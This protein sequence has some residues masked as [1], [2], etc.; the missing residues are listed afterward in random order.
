MEGARFYF[1]DWVVVQLNILYLG[2]ANE[3]AYVL[4]LVA[5]QV[6]L[7]QIYQFKS[8]VVHA[9]ILDLIALQIQLLK[10]LKTAKAS[11]FFDS[12]AVEAE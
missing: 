8:N 12:I 3:L 7:Q 10:L 4:Y 1:G 2:V 6:N 9:S 11:D 5:T